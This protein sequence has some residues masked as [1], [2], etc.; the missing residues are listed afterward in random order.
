MFKNYRN[1]RDEIS[2]TL[3]AAKLESSRSRLLRTDLEPRLP[4]KPIAFPPTIVCDA[5]RG[6]R[7]IR[8]CLFDISPVRTHRN[9]KYFS[10]TIT[11]MEIEVWL[12][13]SSVH[14]I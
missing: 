14:T 6:N 7:G 11:S 3:N 10:S 5:L 13:G 4:T 2:I 9:L 8:P 12:T 1:T